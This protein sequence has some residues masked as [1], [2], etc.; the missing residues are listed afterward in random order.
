MPD[1]IVPARVVALL[2]FSLAGP[3][4]AAASAES[5]SSKARDGDGSIVVTGELKQW[6]KVTLTLDGPFAT[7]RDIDPNPFLDCRMTVSFR[8]ESGEPEYQ[9]PGYFAADGDAAETSSESGTRWRAHLSPDRPG[10]WTYR[11]SFAHGKNAAID[12][13]RGEPLVPYDGK[14]GSFQVGPTDRTGRDFR[15]RAARIRGQ[16]LPPVLGLR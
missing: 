10:T 7:E 13:K 9:V 14:S 15:A 1:R 3:Y 6:H 11:V 8:H 4:Q 12:P 16:A 5:S 2:L